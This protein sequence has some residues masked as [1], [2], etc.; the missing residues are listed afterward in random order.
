MRDDQDDVPGVGHNLPPVRNFTKPLRIRREDIEKLGNKD[1][2]GKRKHVGKTFKMIHAFGGLMET[3]GRREPAAFFE[4]IY[5]PDARELGEIE[6]VHEYDIGEDGE[7]RPPRHWRV[8]RTEKIRCGQISVSILEAEHM[9]YNLSVGVG[10]AAASLFEPRDMVVLHP[11]EIID[12]ILRAS[13]GMQNPPQ[14]PIMLLK[15]LSELTVHDRPQITVENTGLR[16]S[17]QGDGRGDNLRFK[18]DLLCISPGQEFV[19]DVRYDDPREKDVFVFEFSTTA[20]EN[21]ETG[22]ELLA[23][24]MVYLEPTNTGVFVLGYDQKPIRARSKPGTYGFAVV[25]WQKAK[26]AQEREGEPSLQDMMGAAALCDEWRREEVNAVVE[27]LRR[28]LVRETPRISLGIL[29]YVKG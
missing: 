25:T 7:K 4:Q 5:E 18:D 13:P 26:T 29:D 27:L 10:K 14:N 1:K 15:L 12:R 28:E 16:L 6:G 19:L 2:F 24:P 11:S 8:D 20:L 9:L 22:E 23:L 17:D 3:L 21:D